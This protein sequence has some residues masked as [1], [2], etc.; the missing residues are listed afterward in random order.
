MTIA[1]HRLLGPL[2]GAASMILATTACSQGP[3]PRDAGSVVIAPAPDAALPPFRFAPDD[4]AFLDEVE[5]AAFLFMWHECSPTTGMVRD[6]KSAELISI[7]GVGF[8]L[9]AICV[10]AERGWVSRDEAHDRCEL[11]LRSLAANP[12][13]RRFGLF[14]HYLDPDDAGPY[15]KAY[16]HVVST[17]DSALLFAGIITASS[18]FGGDIAKVAD[19]LIAGADWSAF[20]LTDTNRDYERGFISLGWKP[21]E[22]DHPTGAGSLLPFVWADA[23]GEQLLVSFLAVAAPKVEHRVD[24]ALYYRLRRRL[25]SYADSGPLV[26]FPWSGALFTNFFAHCWIDYARFA[27]DDPGAF[28]QRQRARVNWWEN[29]RRAVL[30]HRAK[31]KANPRRLPTLGAN[32]WGLSASDAPT[33]YSVPGLFPDPLPMPGAVKNVDYADVTPKDDYGDAVLAPYGAGCTVMFDPAPAIAALRHYRGLRTR[34]GEA[35][36]W[37]EPDVAAREYGFRDAF[38]AHTDWVAPDYV[39]I[40]EGPLV[41]AIENARTGLIWRTFSK[42]PSVKAGI[43]RLGWR[44]APDGGR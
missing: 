9:S 39:A 31:A 24:P 22:M 35:L 7:A 13:N 29:S 10:G 15:K 19:P 32:A 33:G 6:R 16:E 1:R 12:A 23:G 11:I 40:D 44:S 8:Q 43:T 5:H 34:A 14:F 42:H 30:M 2:A 18:Y 36:V 27:P 37:R 28:G 17:I 25:G 20:V 26:W 4:E 3:R 38:Q 41:L 21:A